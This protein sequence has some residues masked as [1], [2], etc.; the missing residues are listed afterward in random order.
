MET[1]RQAY[2]ALVL[3]VTLG[4]VLVAHGLLKFLI[5]TLPGTAGFFASVG[6]PGWAAYIVAPFEVVAGL[7]LIAGYRATWVAAMALPVLLGAL[8]AHAGNG[9][10][11]TNK[12]GGWEFPAVLV[13]LAIGVVLLGDGALSVRR[14]L[15]AAPSRAATAR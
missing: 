6:F 2:A 11:F 4:C 13:M 1:Q 7:A 12:D 15:R 3:R 14:S 8:A 9:W 5:F 10:L